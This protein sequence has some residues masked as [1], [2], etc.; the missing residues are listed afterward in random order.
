MSY[1]YISHF[2]HLSIPTLHRIEAP[3]PHDGHV[4]PLSMY[5]P[6]LN[7]EPRVLLVELVGVHG[8]TVQ[9]VAE[10]LV[11]GTQ[12]N[13]LRLQFLEEQ[14]LGL[15]LDTFQGKSCRT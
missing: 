14:S 11:P 1:T 3:L 2:L 13:F 6:E 5:F 8:C 9:L 15:G 7:A 4:L 10:L 12:V